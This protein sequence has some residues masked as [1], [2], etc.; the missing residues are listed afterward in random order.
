MFLYSHVLYPTKSPIFL[1]KSHVQCFQSQKQ[2]C[3]FRSLAIF[4]TKTKTDCNCM[5][6]NFF[7]IELIC[8]VDMST[9][10]YLKICG[11]YVFSHGFL[12]A[13]CKMTT[14][15][16]TSCHFTCKPGIFSYQ[17]LFKS[18]GNQAVS[19]P[20]QIF[21]QNICNSQSFLPIPHI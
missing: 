4:W 19:K 21:L 18:P 2:I 3:N 12:W 7:C 15:N 1:T 9:Y 16:N 6:K 20:C 13:Q 8:L 14:V 11:Y 5:Q 17:L 10:P